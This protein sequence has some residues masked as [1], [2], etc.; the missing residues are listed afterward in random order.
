MTNFVCV[1]GVFV[2][3]EEARLPLVMSGLE[4]GAGVFTAMR[5]HDGCIECLD[6]HLKRLYEHARVHELE[7]QE[8]EPQLFRELIAK[9]VAR[10][11][12]YRVKVMLVPTRPEA[13]R[14]GKCSHVIYL[15]PFVDQAPEALKVGL[16]PYLPHSSLSR[17]KT[18][19]RLDRRLSY[20]QALKS[21]LHEV[22]MTTMEGVLLEALWANIFWLHEGRLFTPDP[23]LPYMMGIALGHALDAAKS[24]GLKVEYVTARLDDIPADAELYLSNALIWAKPV[25]QVQERLFS[26]NLPFEQK[27]QA[28]LKEEILKNSFFA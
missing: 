25:I 15:T 10:K 3:E 4:T 6:E 5:L 13:T 16:L 2:P 17:I 1:D 27:L 18:L 11:G 7:V 23:K 9:N 19:S 20:M 21:G 12:T 28:A 24:L 22:I 8:I 26:R 14:W